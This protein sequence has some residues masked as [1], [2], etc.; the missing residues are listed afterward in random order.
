MEFRRV[1]FR[2]EH[3]VRLRVASNGDAFL[4]FA[5]GGFGTASGKCEFNAHTLEYT[6]PAESRHG[7]A[8]LR[9][10]YPLEM[11]SPKNDD[12]MN[13]TFGYRSDR[14]RETSVVRLHVS[15]AEG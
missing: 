12:S 4:P 10:K 9:S 14:D 1:L 3:S 11:I 13:S 15:D 8:A 2:S 6:P 5:Q 7:D